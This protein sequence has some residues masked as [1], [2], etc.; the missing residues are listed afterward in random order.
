[1]CIECSACHFG[2]DLVHLFTEGFLIWC[3]IH[4]AVRIVSIS[5]AYTWTRKMCVGFDF[6]QSYW[7]KISRSAWGKQNK[8]LKPKY[9]ITT[10]KPL[11]HCTRNRNNH[12]P[13]GWWYTICLWPKGFLDLDKTRVGWYVE[14]SFYTKRLLGSG[15]EYVEM[16]KARNKT[17][18]WGHLISVG[19]DKKLQKSF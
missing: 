2:F 7:V 17:A 18:G 3:L 13:E 15:Q 6:Y 5:S 19:D 8:V 16:W 10:K 12:G 1:M 4:S 9:E 11:M 14:I